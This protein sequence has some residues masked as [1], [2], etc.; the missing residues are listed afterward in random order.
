MNG[1]SKCSS[2]RCASA[3]SR[4]IRSG[5]SDEERALTRVEMIADLDETIARSIAR[6]E[7][8]WVAVIPERPYVVPIR[9]GVSGANKQPPKCGSRLT[10]AARGKAPARLTGVASRIEARR[11]LFGRI[12]C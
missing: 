4:S 9:R 11:K 12:A 2:N 10:G 5:L 3:E 1:R 6:A 7:D 8:R